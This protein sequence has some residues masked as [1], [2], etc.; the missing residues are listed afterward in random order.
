MSLAAQEAWLTTTTMGAL[1]ISAFWL[2]QTRGNLWGAG[3]GGGG[4]GGDGAKEG[5]GKS[6]TS[7]ES[8]VGSKLNEVDEADCWKKWIVEWMIR[9]TT[10]R[11]MSAHAA[12][13]YASRCVIDVYYGF[14]LQVTTRS[15][16]SLSNVWFG[17]VEPAAGSMKTSGGACKFRAQLSSGLVQNVFSICAIDV[18][19]FESNYIW[20]NQLT[21]LSL[22]LWWNLF[23]QR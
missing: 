23:G 18:C 7:Q 9:T 8:S 1:L 17:W 20:S 13:I 19:A 5:G 22:S 15:H 14:G 16:Q 21:S 12:P 10:T 3:G 2:L 6:A 11:A 4:G